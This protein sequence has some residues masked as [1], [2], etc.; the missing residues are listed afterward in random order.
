[1]A[2]PAYLT[3]EGETQGKIEGDCEQKGF[4]KTIEVWGVDHLI[5]IP[6]DINTGLATGSRVH[7]P[8]KIT[9][10]LGSQSPLIMKAL[11]DGEKMKKF[12][13]KYYKIHDNKQTNFYTVTLEDA[14]VVSTTTEKRFIK[15]AGEDKIDDLNVIAFTYS[16]ISM[17]D[18]VTSKN[19]DDNW[20][21][22]NT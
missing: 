9:T 6:S 11:A 10:P 7:H 19:A 20:K 2:F 12:E 13:L 17:E 16:K 8:M 18:P 14:I 21:E 15:V 22:P 3:L 5:D 4:E 1:M